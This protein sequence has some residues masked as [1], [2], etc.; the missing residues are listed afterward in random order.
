M[1]GKKNGQAESKASTDSFISNFFR[2]FCNHYGKIENY[3]KHL[4]ECFNFKT[5]YFWF[6]AEIASP[7]ARIGITKKSRDNSSANV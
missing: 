7:M 4:L 6:I 3:S 1:G 2:L 5:L